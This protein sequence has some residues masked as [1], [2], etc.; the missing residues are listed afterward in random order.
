MKQK[1][2]YQVYDNIIILICTYYM[3]I[4]IYFIYCDL[5]EANYN[6]KLFSSSSIPLD[7]S[8]VILLDKLDENSLILLMPVTVLILIINR[9]IPLMILIIRILIISR[10]TPLINNAYNYTI[11]NTYSN[12]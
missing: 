2:Y 3:C 5:I 8:R 10:I 4:Y 1:R 12:Y 9:I 7:K 11:N 6:N